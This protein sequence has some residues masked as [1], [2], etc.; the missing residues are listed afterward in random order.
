MNVARRAR[1]REWAYAGLCAL[2]GDFY[3]AAVGG[4]AEPDRHFWIGI[5]CIPRDHVPVDVLQG[6]AEAFVI[7]ANRLKLAGN[8]LRDNCHVVPEG[9]LP[10]KRQAREV[11]GVLFEQQ[12]AP[13][14]VELLVAEDDEGFGELGDEAWVFAPADFVDPVA[15]VATHPSALASTQCTSVR[16]PQPVAPLR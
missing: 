3:Q 13:A 1:R 7:D 2:V 5:V 11:L 4:G 6:V 10:L 8:R 9:C 16:T 14:A 12:H 15:R